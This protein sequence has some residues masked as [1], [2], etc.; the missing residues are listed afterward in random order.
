VP[1]LY[2]IRDDA[3]NPQEMGGPR[4]FRGQVVWVV[5]RRD[6]LVETVGDE[7]VWDVEQSDGRWGVDKIWSIN[8]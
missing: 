8:K 1:G 2:S 7:E 3:P 4:E 6:I 5:G